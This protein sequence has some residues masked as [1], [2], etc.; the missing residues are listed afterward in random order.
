MPKIWAI[1][2]RFLFG[3]SWILSISFEYS[4]K[5]LESCDCVRP[6]LLSLLIN[7]WN[8]TSMCLDIPHI[9]IS[10]QFFWW[11]IRLSNPFVSTDPEPL[12]INILHWWS[13]KW[14]LICFQHVFYV[15]SHNIIKDCFVILV[16]IISSILH[17]MLL[18]VSHA[19]VSLESIA[20]I[21]LSSLGLGA[22]F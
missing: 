6:T 11:N 19:Y 8:F 22:I 4:M 13:E 20:S 21:I 10:N 1:F 18:P 3:F 15:F 17:V 7:K 9:G 2:L 12:I 14:G 5:V 16:C